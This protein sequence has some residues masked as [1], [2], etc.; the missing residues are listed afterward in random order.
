LLN[1]LKSVFTFGASPSPMGYLLW[2][3]RATFLALTIGVATGS[4][5]FL[6]K[7][8]QESTWGFVSFALI[9]VLGLV[10]IAI[11]VWARNKQ[12][13][14]ISALYFGLLMG[15]FLGQLFWAA[16]EPIFKQYFHGMV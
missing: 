14:T 8:L 16:L 13:T 6:D 9:L 7:R 15:F 11:D 2:I 12:I 3:L 1:F 4:L 10:V 5:Y